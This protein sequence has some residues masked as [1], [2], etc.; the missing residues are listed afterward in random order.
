MAVNVICGVVLFSQLYHL[1]HRSITA[2]LSRVTT[3]LKAGIRDIRG[4]T[5]VMRLTII[6][7]PFKI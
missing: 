5:S 7:K 6:S 1:Y 4:H 3:T 2:L